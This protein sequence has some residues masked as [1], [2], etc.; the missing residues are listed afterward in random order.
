MLPLVARLQPVLEEEAVEGVAEEALP[1]L[2]LKHPA[3]PGALLLEHLV[4]AERLEA[5]DI[6]VLQ[7]LLV[8]LPQLE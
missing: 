2:S 3:Q 8:V 7:A 4:E 6:P 1:P 5:E